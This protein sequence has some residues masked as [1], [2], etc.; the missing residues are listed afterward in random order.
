MFCMFLPYSQ[1]HRFQF[2]NL[3]WNFFPIFAARFEMWVFVHFILL[4]NVKTPPWRR[5]T[6]WRICSYELCTFKVAFQIKRC[7]KDVAMVRIWKSS[8]YTWIKLTNLLCFAVGVTA[9][10]NEA[11]NVSFVWSIND[12]VSV[13]CHKVEMTFTRFSILF[14]SGFKCLVIQHFTDIFHHKLST[15]N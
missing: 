1:M 15:K 14:G 8:E 6:Y 3:N 5:S 7:C 9:V 12:L 2:W 11:W 10:I 13:Q 4:L